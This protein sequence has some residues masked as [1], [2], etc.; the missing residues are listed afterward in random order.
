MKKHVSQ[1]TESVNEL[2][3]RLRRLEHDE[4][5]RLNRIEQSCKSDGEQV[6]I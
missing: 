6:E 1:L 2:A 3:A 5:S 4:R